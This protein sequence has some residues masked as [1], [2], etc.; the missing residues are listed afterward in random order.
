MFGGFYFAW[1]SFGDSPIG[2]PPEPPPPPETF[3]YQSLVVPCGT[4]TCSVISGRGGRGDFAVYSLQDTIEQEDLTG[5]ELDCPSRAC[6]SDPDVEIYSLQDALI[7]NGTP[8]T[9][10]VTCPTG[11]VCPPGVLPPTITY[12]PGTFVVPDPPPPAP[13]FPIVLTG[14]GCSS[15][16]T[17]VL[18][19]GSSAASIQSARNQIFQQMAQQQAECDAKTLVHPK[20]PPLVAISL[21]NIQQYFCLDT[22]MSANITATYSPHTLPTTY[23][24]NSAL[25]PPGV[26]QSQT[27]ST[28]ILDGIPT[29]TGDYTFTVQAVA[30]GA[31]GSKTY[32]MSIIG[33]DNAS[34]LPNGTPGTPYSETFTAT[35]MP[36]ILTWFVSVGVLPDGLSLNPSTGELSGTPTTDVI[37]TFTILVTNGTLACQKEFDIQIDLIN[38][39]LNAPVLT[40][41]SV[42]QA[43]SDTLTPTF[44]G[45]YT[46]TITSG[47]LPAGLTIGVASGI[48]SGTPT[49]I[50]NPTFTAHVTNG[51]TSCSQIFSIE[52]TCIPAGGGGQITPIG[53]PS[54]T[55]TILNLSSGNMT[56]RLYRN[57]VAFWTPFPSI[58]PGG[59]AT[60]PADTLG[61]GFTVT[62]DNA[63]VMQG[64]FLIPQAGYLVA[65]G[66]D[67]LFVFKDCL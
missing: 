30:P 5:L 6:V 39:Y 65:A 48:I 3:T 58:A 41:G 23:T 28:L 49:M 22:E 35:S 40:G 61:I 32:T 27:T 55:Y 25:L 52:I 43:Y 20:P 2:V 62:C 44:A 42:N 13:G 31:A 21:S 36:G 8:L 33:I 9:V 11:Y 19:F 37:D 10:I 16:I 45:P 12:P 63:Q 46:F 51:V 14:A 17:V 4:K 64:P 60:S 53:G 57:G 1:P 34:P 54:A 47:A 59:S 29:T 50:E 56:G 66:F 67:Y 38:C 18:P 26:N 24:V 15:N 7:Y